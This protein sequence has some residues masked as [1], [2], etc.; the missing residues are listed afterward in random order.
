MQCAWQA[1]SPCIDRYEGYGDHDQCQTRQLSY[2]KEDR[3]MRPIYGCPEK[4]PESSLRTWL[5]F[6]K[7]V[8]GFCSDRYQECAYKILKFVALPVP[9]IILIGGTQKIWGVPG[10]AHAPYYPN[11]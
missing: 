3:A 8:T 11:F 10:F 6:P 9:E 4:F 5:L 1:G 2:R 7:F